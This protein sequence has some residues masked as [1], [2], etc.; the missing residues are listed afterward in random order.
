MATAIS[1]HLR[2]AK[3]HIESM[4]KRLDD[5]HLSDVEDEEDLENDIF[6]RALDQGKPFIF[7]HAT[8]FT[9]TNFSIFAHNLIE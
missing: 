6:N 4:Q 9:Q 2:K 7:Y 1:N 8:I 3:S 5:D